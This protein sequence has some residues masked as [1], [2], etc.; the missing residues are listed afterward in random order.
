MWTACS[1][2]PVF[3]AAIT[4]RKRSCSQAAIVRCLHLRSTAWP[5][6]AGFP[7][8]CKRSKTAQS[9]SPILVASSPQR[10]QWRDLLCLQQPP[11]RHQN[12]PP[13]KPGRFETTS[14]CPTQ[15]FRWL[16]WERWPPPTRSR[17]RRS[18]G[19]AR[20]STTRPREPRFPPPSPMPRPHRRRRGR[21]SVPR[22][23]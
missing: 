8:T 23:A 20:R 17:T 4:A 12:L 2:C 7:P 1:G 11:A 3:S 15:A 9:R 13:A 19:G 21:R 14:R 22:R 18:A 16:E 10:P 6:A 5:E